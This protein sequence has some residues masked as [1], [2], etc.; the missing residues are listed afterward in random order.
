MFDPPSDWLAR[1][2]P[3]RRQAE[4]G[5]WVAVLLMQLVFNTT[6][7]LIDARRAGIAL[8]L[9]EPLVWEATSNLVVGLLIPAVAAFERRFP[10]R[11]STVVRNLP[12][13]L[14][15]SVA[16]CL[17]HV[18]AILALRYAIY[19]LLGG[20]YRPGSLGT[21]LLYEYLKDVR[22]YVLIM[23]AILG[24]R[25]LLLR[26][27]G[28]A[29]VLD[30]ADPPAGA[31]PAP[32]G[33]ALAPARPERFL[34]RKLRK[35]FLIAA[36]EIEWL[37]AQGNYVGLHVNGHDYLLRST[38]SDFLEQLDPARFARVHRSFAV[39]LDRVAEIE[40]TDGGDARL[41]MKDGSQVP[42]SRRYRDAL[43]GPV[44]IA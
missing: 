15:G 34:V 31:A 20:S 32:P 40:P 25:F 14:G 10:L 43:A 11:W 12:A 36:G 38:L 26:A 41:K 5:F 27:Q 22:S 39:N 19:P 30:A 28:E 8:P 6:V 9:W 1:Y 18:A 23:A 7:T 24:Y 17:A 33:P 35:E 37:Q 44:A 21:Q 4:I 3:W 16:F 42:C 13:H 29:R 2:Q